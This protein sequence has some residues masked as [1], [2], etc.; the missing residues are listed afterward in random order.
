M[1]KRASI[2][3]GLAL[4]AVVGLPTNALALDAPVL[5]NG[6]G[7]AGCN[8]LF[9]I[10]W[11]AVSGATSYNVLGNYPPYSGYAVLKT[12]TGLQTMVHASDTDQLTYMEVEACDS[13]GC[14]PVS[15]QITLFWY[16]GC[17]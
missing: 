7:P 4:L 12:V 16:S 15:N 14:G 13:S 5:N 11:T 3:A 9:I 6:G 17:P 10:Q 2:A 8:G 1:G